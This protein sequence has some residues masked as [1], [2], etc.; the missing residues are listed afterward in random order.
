MTKSESAIL[1]LTVATFFAGMF[2]QQHKLVPPSNIVTLAQFS[3]AMP[4]PHKVI[5]FE[6]NGSTYVE[7]IGSLPGFPTVPSGPPAYI[8]DSSGRIAYWTGDTGVARFRRSRQG[9]VPRALI[10]TLR[11]SAFLCDSAVIGFCSSFY[12]RDAEERRDTQRRFPK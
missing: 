2:Y 3:A 9:K 6:K 5:A 10:S 12:R 1:I 4:P 11:I 7:I 8:F